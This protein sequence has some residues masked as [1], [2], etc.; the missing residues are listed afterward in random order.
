ML[1]EKYEHMYGFIKYYN[2]KYKEDYEGMSA[3]L[4]ELKYGSGKGRKIGI[5]SKNII[6]H[7]FG[8]TFPEVNSKNVTVRKKSTTSS[9]K[10]NVNILNVFSDE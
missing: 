9:A 5:A 3:E 1:V 7:I 6:S 10:N 2:E 8:I 4:G